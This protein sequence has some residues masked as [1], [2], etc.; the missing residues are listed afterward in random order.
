MEFVALDVEAFHLGIGDDDSP[1]VF[2]GVE[3]ADH[4]QPGLGG[5]RADQIDD[6]PIADERF[7]APVL[8]DEREQAMLDLVPLCAAET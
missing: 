7:G 5:R 1:G 6:D 8:G 4:L 3:F 2:V